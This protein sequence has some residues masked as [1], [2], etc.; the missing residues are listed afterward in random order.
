MWIRGEPNKR[1]S[2]TSIRDGQLNGADA[3]GVLVVDTPLAFIVFIISTQ[4]AVVSQPAPD[5]TGTF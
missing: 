1:P 4:D 5:P 2:L 3:G